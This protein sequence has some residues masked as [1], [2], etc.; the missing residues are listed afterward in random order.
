MGVAAYWF[1]VVVEATFGWVVGEEFFKECVSGGWVV[2][3]GAGLSGSAGC[4]WVWDAAS[5]ASSKGSGVF[6]L[7]LCIGVRVDREICIHCSGLIC[8]KY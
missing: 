3:L 5:E 8:A 2:A 4:F 1:S 6:A 7:V